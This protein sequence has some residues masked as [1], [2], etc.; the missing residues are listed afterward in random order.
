MKTPEWLSPGLYGAACGAIAVAVLGF[1]WG[2]WVTGKTARTMA[3]EL[4]AKDVVTALTVVCLD[5]AKRDPLLTERTAAI[6]AASSW[7]RGDMVAKNGWATLPGATDANRAVAN[8]C[9]DKMSA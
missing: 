6:K 7:S 1:T 2:G 5:Q 8:A 3:T 9:A 4:S